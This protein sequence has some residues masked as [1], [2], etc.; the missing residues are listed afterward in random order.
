MHWLDLIQKLLSVAVSLLGLWKCYPSFKQW[1][2]SEN[3]Q[4]FWKNTKKVLRGLAVL[5]T[6]LLVV[7]LALAIGA[8]WERNYSPAMPAAAF[9]HLCKDT[10]GGAAFAAL[11]IK[12]F[13]HYT[14]KLADL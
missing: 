13:W 12:G 2:R 5:E 9:L 11:A 7:L 14:R 1:L 8:F 4:T 10:L 3:Q 6:V